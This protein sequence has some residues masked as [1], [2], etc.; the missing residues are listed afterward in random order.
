MVLWTCLGLISSCRRLLIQLNVECKSLTLQQKLAKEAYMKQ[1][2]LQSSQPSQPTQ[3]T[4][5]AASGS[6]VG[7]IRWCF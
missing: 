7:N 3:S 6:K 4:T 1:S 5:S 2:E